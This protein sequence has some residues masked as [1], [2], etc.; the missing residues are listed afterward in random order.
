MAMLFYNDNDTNSLHLKNIYLEGELEENSTTEF[1]RWFKMKI[2]AWL[3]D[4]C[5]FITSM[6]HLRLQLRTYI[7]FEYYE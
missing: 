3:T 4:K 5:A 1:F 2:N 6:H 7:K